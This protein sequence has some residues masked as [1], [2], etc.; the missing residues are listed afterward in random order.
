MEIGRYSE[1]YKNNIQY[2]KQNEYCK[3]HE[4]CHDNIDCLS[5]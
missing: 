3:L 5:I 1:E 4:L 2:M